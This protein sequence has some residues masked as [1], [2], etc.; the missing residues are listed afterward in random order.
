MSKATGA[1]KPPMSDEAVRAK[2]GKNWPEWFSILDRADALDM[3][4]R[5]IASYLKTRHGVA[6]WWCQMVAVGYEQSRG[7]REKHQKPSGFEIGAS[8]T[9][10]APLSRLFSAWQDAKARARWLADPGFD[11]RKATPGKSLRITWVDGKTSVDANFY[12]KGDGKSQVTVAHGKLAT[13][14]AAARMKKYWGEQLARLKE[15]LEG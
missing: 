12:S 1:R 14:G 9:I 5:Q 6:D 2:T 7:L 10:T 4:H 8:K 13:A 15:Q 11:V 3:D